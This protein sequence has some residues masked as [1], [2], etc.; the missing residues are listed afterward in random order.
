MAEVEQEKGR[1]RNE[2][3]GTDTGGEGLTAVVRTWPALWLR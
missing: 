2:S 1:V 3:R